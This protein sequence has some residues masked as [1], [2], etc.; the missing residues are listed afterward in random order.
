MQIGALTTNDMTSESESVF[1]DA[2]LPSKDAQSDIQTDQVVG[3]SLKKKL[4]TKDRLYQK[5]FVH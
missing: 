3:P 1:A 2:S 5:P 4:E